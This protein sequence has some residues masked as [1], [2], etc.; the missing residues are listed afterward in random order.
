MESVTTKRRPFM[1]SKLW[2]P[3]LLGALFWIWDFDDGT[4]YADVRDTTGTFSQESVEQANKVIEEIHEKY[5][6]DVVVE[7]LP[8][9]GGQKLDDL[10]LNGAKKA[11]VN[12]VYVLITRNPGN[13]S[14]WVH[15]DAAK[16]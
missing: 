12:G 15:D 10:V 9:L 3:L 1:R 14:V 2:L 7:V 6:K 16:A 8:S 4:A 5:G 11:N 13:V